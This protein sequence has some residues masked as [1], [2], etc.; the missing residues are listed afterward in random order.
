MALVI[1]TN[2]TALNSQRNLRKSEGPLNTAM[3]R[4][5]SGLRINSAKDDAAGLAIATRMDA[6]VRGLS[7]AI[8]NAN[9][10]LSFAQ[11]AEGA[12]S[13]M[14]SDVERIYELSVQSA[15]YNTPQDRKSMDVEVKELI[16]ELDRVVTQTRFNGEQFLNKQVSWSYQVGTK[17]DETITL[18]T[19]NISPTA[20]G[21][22]TTYNQNF[23]ESDVSKAAWSTYK[24]AMDESF[25][26]D[27]KLNNVGLGGAIAGEDIKNSSKTIIDRV[28]KYTNET[29]VKAMS[30]GNALVGKDALAVASEGVAG[31]SGFMTVN[32]VAIGSFSKAQ[33]SDEEKA[34]I[35]QE[36]TSAEGDQI[37]AKQAELE[38]NRDQITADFQKKVETGEIKRTDDQK[39]M[40][41]KDVA[42]A[43][44]DKYISNG[45]SDQTVNEKV[46]G[47]VAKR[48][49]EAI[50]V[51]INDKSTE[52]GIKAYVV[53]QSRLVLANT[54]GAG[55]TLSVDESRFTSK[56]GDATKDVTL[57]FKTGA[58]GDSVEGGKNGMI[59]LSDKRFGVG[60]IQ[61]GND[62]TTSL[63]GYGM[64]TQ[65]GDQANIQQK[66]E[67]SD[68][69]A[70]SKKSVAD[71][72]I[73]TADNAKL[74]MMVSEEVLD[75]LNSFKSTIGAKMN[76]IE[77]TVRNLDNVRENIS[78]AKSRILDAD[79]ATETAD[80]TK[81]MILHQAGISILAQS[82]SLPQSVLALLRT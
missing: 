65:N 43:L 26:T 36:V 47:V 59:I 67:T 15:S 25:G 2:L 40:S 52:T 19:R 77:S 74:T 53:S 17:V 3:Q 60:T 51:V 37:K 39:G 1:N 8:R 78:A 69:I 21:V 57:G 6:Q 18:N 61:F 29:N 11:T 28:N 68:S 7:V 22:T 38:A 72:S 34:Q 20:L 23:N 56:T 35:K 10:G 27:V 41:D 79:F 46:Q 64:V 32:G 42:G 14:V 33:I 4:L 48:T 50:A 45:G 16:S 54:T 24:G 58:N 31:Q 75:V 44:A 71:L 55:I 76:R 73:D 82:N 62:K 80:M 13:E 12:V 9:D 30:F 81:A 49:A 5:S 63:F 66:R 70:L